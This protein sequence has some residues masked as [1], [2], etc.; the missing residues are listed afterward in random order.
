MCVWEVGGGVS[1]GEEGCMSVRSGARERAKKEN[2][3]R[4]E[5]RGEKKGN[6]T[7]KRVNKVNNNRDIL[8]KIN[9]KDIVAECFMA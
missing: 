1:G 4:K 7:F 9:T 8:K 3:K 5:G 2:R 6:V